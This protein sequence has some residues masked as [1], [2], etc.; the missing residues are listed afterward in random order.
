MV[1]GIEKRMIVDD[2]TDRKI[3]IQRMGELSADTKT[4]IYAWALMTNHATFSY[5]ALKLVF[6]D[7]CVGF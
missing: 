1:P 5:A 4:I 6:P 3:F 2:D 7:S